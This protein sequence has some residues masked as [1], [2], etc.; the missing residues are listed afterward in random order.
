MKVKNGIASSRSLE[1]TPY[2]WNVRLPRK[3]GWIRPELDGDEAEEQAG[4]REEN[5][6]GKSDQHEQN[7]AA[8]TSAEPCCRG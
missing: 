8:R 6:A 4:R 1:T 3:V 2:S 7:H 5:A